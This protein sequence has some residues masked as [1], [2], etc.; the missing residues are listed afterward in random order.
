MRGDTYR[1]CVR[2]GGLSRPALSG[3]GLGPRGIGF[4]G[5]SALAY[6]GWGGRRT[7][8]S[9]QHPVDRGPPNILRS[10]YRK[11]V[12]VAHLVPAFE[13][14]QRSQRNQQ[15][16]SRRIRETGKL[17]RI[18]QFYSRDIGEA[19]QN[20]ARL[21]FGELILGGDYAPQWQP[22]FAGER[23]GLHVGLDPGRTVTVNMARHYLCLA[24]NNRVVHSCKAERI[25]NGKALEDGAR[26]ASSLLRDLGRRRHHRTSAKQCQIGFDNCQPRP[27]TSQMAAVDLPGARR[28]SGQGRFLI[29]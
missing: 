15:L 19:H 18:H 8:D 23:A 10:L 20:D 14:G 21:E 4:C 2:P 9:W 6:S 22:F 1:P 17:Q 7:N 24:L 3:R 26:R 11:T 13:A 5:R 16:I 12:A 28:G 29:E 27:L 25:K